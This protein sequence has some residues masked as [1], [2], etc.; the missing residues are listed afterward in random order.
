MKAKL[1]FC[2]VFFM[3][4]KIVFGQALYNVRLDLMVYGPPNSY[5]C[6]HN[7]DMH[8]KTD[9][10]SITM[11]NPSPGNILKDSRSLVI[12]IDEITTEFSIWGRNRYKE[13]G[14]CNGDDSYAV[15]NHNDC[16]NQYKTTSYWSKQYGL[17]TWNGY[18]KITYYPANLTVKTV[19]GPKYLVDDVLLENDITT[20]TATQGFPSDAYTWRYQISKTGVWADFPIAFQGKSTISFTGTQLLGTAADFY[21][22]VGGGINVAVW[23]KDSLGSG[24]LIKYGNNKTLKPKYYAPKIVSVTPQI[25]KC[26]NSVTSSVKIKLD[27][28]LEAGYYIQFLNL[29][30]SI[31][32]DVPF[33]LVSGNF[34]PVDNTYEWINLDMNAAYHIN[35]YDYL[36]ETQT[37]ADAIYYVKTNSFDYT[38]NLWPPVLQTSIIKNGIYCNG[39]K[40]ASLDG[41]VQGGTPPYNLT[42][43]NKT[44][45]AVLASRSLVNANP[46]Q[47]VLDIGAAKDLPLGDYHLAVQD[48][49]GCPAQ[50]DATITQ[51]TTP[52][53]KVSEQITDV[54]GYGLN[55]GIFEIKL[56]GGT[57]TNPSG[58]SLPQLKKGI[59]TYTAQLTNSS[60]NEFTFSFSNLPAGNYEFRAADLNMTSYATSIKDSA[61]CLAKETLTIIQPPPLLLSIE[62]TQAIVCNGDATASVIGHAKGG[63]PFTTG[64]PYTYA[65][66]YSSDGSSSPFN[67]ITASDSALNQRIAGFY[68][69]QVKD[70]NNN[71]TTQ[72]YQVIQPQKVDYIV[73]VKN[74]TCLNWTDGALMVSSITGGTSPYTITWPDETHGSQIANLAQGYYLVKV[75]DALNCIV[76][77][78]VKVKDTLNGITLEQGSY[79]MPHCYGEDNGSMGVKVTVE[80][81]P[82]TVLWDN[83]I[84]DT[85]LSNIK[86]G[87]Y[88][89]QVLNNNNCLKEASFTLLNPN[90]IPL[91]LDAERYLCIG[92]TADYDLEVKDSSY[93][94][95]WL[96]EE[97]NTIEPK[98]SLILPGKYTATINDQH[99]CSR[100]ESINIHR[101]ESTI[102]SDFVVSSQVFSGDEVSLVN[103]TQDQYTDSCAWNFGPNPNIEVV[104]S[105]YA[106]AT[107]IFKEKGTYKIGLKSHLGNCVKVQEKEIIVLE[108]TFDH[109]PYNGATSF[110]KDFEVMPNPNDGNFEVQIRME[111]IAAVKLRLLDFYSKSDIVELEYH[112]QKD[113]L[114]PM[115]VSLAPGTYILFLE[116]PY[117]TRI[118]K[119]IIM[120]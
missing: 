3:A 100:T 34:D 57:Y 60:N 83:G 20:L 6:E 5:D 62:Q 111:D 50:A 7:V 9:K 10:Q 41:K 87:T 118:N 25:A 93:S 56:K 70:Q 26:S 44:T 39:G 113:Y 31:Q 17:T 76:S 106:Y 77:K 36:D 73:T 8:F 11:G 67:V 61:G 88:T 120:Q 90:Q 81:M 19:S 48:K 114:I 109:K 46:G 51:P 45:G 96:G 1:F 13:S 94:Y 49:N 35:V 21:N 29:K 47:Y 52:L 55:N 42:Y 97:L 63:K 108:P 116:T 24:N 30:G 92:Q 85:L 22:T 2:I 14:G 12:S 86:A 27:R 54:S 112:D 115:H 79:K 4:G 78:N 91:N 117:G 89:V 68:K 101:V 95:Q 98:V 107:L 72:I 66:S 53:S 15:A 69:L 64:K 110:I 102:A 16:F 103:I 59:T 28:A 38:L 65:W 82:Y 23:A 58:Y 104:A 18:G 75:S 80:S 71:T 40:D 99:G 119:V 84:T 32:S 74:V 33:T 105:S 37:K 43:T